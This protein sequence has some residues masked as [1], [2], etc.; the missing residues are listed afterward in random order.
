MP[1]AKLC[2]RNPIPSR[3]RR[4]KVGVDKENIP[5]G[6]I[7]KPLYNLVQDDK[8]DLKMKEKPNDFNI[9][10]FTYVARSTASCQFWE[11]QSPSFIECVLQTSQKFSSTQGILQLQDLHV[12]L[13]NECRKCI[14][15]IVEEKHWSE[16]LQSNLYVATHGLR[17]A[18]VVLDGDDRK[19]HDSM[20]K[21]LYHSLV[22]VSD[23]ISH[24]I[25]IDTVVAICI[26]L[27]ECL[28]RLLLTLSSEGL[29]F[30]SINGSFMNFPIPTKSQ[31]MLNCSSIPRHQL[32]KIGIHSTL[33][34]LKVIFH[35]KKCG[36]IEDKT[37]GK[38]FGIL[39][40]LSYDFTDVMCETISHVCLVWVRVYAGN[41]AKSLEIISFA[42]GAHRLL[43]DA[44]ASE[45]NNKKA[46]YLRRAAILALLLKVD[47][48]VDDLPNEIEREL[49]Q[50]CGE[51]ALNWAWKTAATY[52]Q[53]TEIAVPSLEDSNLQ[54][55]HFQ[56]GKVLDDL[57]LLLPRKTMSYI[58][59]CTYRVLHVGI[60]PKQNVSL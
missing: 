22:T 57:F 36:N 43:W 35:H 14:K 18:T 41:G 58:E 29:E 1:S 52:V 30:E 37:T 5:P 9:A 21:I 26:A 4:R 28:G 2:E 39:T 7:L 48:S 53:K 17:A 50:K 59:Y 12:D 11:K 24:I 6:E 3:R 54:Q 40:D 15:E 51:P 45:G 46:M 13:L 33:A 60:R 47:D 32:F 25:K 23:R 27:Y 42:K 55:F 20:I 10:D 8:L 34:V 56:I 38:M 44:A 31:K 49:L 19:S 16:R